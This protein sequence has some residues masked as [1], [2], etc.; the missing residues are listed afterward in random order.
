MSALTFAS[1]LKVRLSHKVE[2]LKGV[3]QEALA[4]IASAPMTV[5][6]AMSAS[7]NQIN[8]ARR[9]EN[10]RLAY[11]FVTK[12]L[13]NSTP[14]SGHFLS[15]VLERGL[16]P[17]FKVSMKKDGGEEV[18]EMTLLESAVLHYLQSEPKWTGG[19]EVVERLIRAGADIH[20][21]NAKGST[22][23]ERA[24]AND[25]KLGELILNTYNDV[26]VKNPSMERGALTP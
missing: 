23:V 17:N 26:K 10:D 3:A 2:Q 15:E 9:E 18:R 16:D 11:A 14:L 20:A 22:L 12:V 13:G 8:T 5:A 4:S 21:M 7:V 25:P 19:S 6:N 24:F 1:G